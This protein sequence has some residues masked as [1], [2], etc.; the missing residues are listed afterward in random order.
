MRLSESC[1]CCLLSSLAV[2][3]PSSCGL[4]VS[5][6]PQSCEHMTSAYSRG[7]TCFSHF[8][9][10][11]A[12]ARAKV[13]GQDTSSLL[14]LS[15]STRSVHLWAFVFPPEPWKGSLRHGRLVGGPGQALL[16][17][18][19]CSQAPSRCPAHPPVTPACVLPPRLDREHRRE[20]LDLCYPETNAQVR[21][22]SV[23]I[24]RA[25]SFT[26]RLK[27]TSPDWEGRL[28][29]SWLQVE[30][31]LRGLATVNLY[32]AIQTRKTAGKGARLS[33]DWPYEPTL[34]LLVS[35]TVCGLTHGEGGKALRHTHGFGTW[36]DG[37]RHPC[38]QHTTNHRV[39]Q[40]GQRGSLRPG[41]EL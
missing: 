39:T 23:N 29:W 31:W 11:K 5:W 28:G 2:Q 32:P 13:Y 25:N 40:L 14:F 35:T 36:W 30:G 10:G 3:G 20:G 4:W 19:G 41:R 8:I 18:S 33:L 21:V 22:C 1:F 34:C 26:V 6:V 37:N 15:A 7:Q 27:N 38:H 24:C 9:R 12:E 17:S 16:F